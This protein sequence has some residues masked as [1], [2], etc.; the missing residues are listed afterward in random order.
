VSAVLD[1]E[2]LLDAVEPVVDD[3][4]T[5]G[6]RNQLDSTRLTEP[7]RRWVANR[8]RYL[9]WRA[10][11]TIGKSH[12]QAWDIVHTARGT[13]PCRPVKRPPVLLLVV[14]YSWAQMDPLCKKLWDLLPKDEIHP[15]V[16]YE[17][18]NGFRGFKEP[19]IP[20]VSGPGAGSAISFATYE[21]GAGRIMG[22]QV[23]G[24]Y[25]DEP[26][27]SS[28]YGE[29]VPRLNSKKGFLRISFTPTPESPDLEYMRD[30][31]KKAAD[32][33]GKRGI[34]EQQTS[35]TEGALVRRHGFGAAAIS[36][37]I[38]ELPA[39]MTADEIAESLDRY[40]DE[41]RD[42]REHGAWYPLAK[43]RWVSTFT[44]E[45]VSDAPPPGGCWLVVS[46]DHGIQAGKQAAMASAYQGRLNL[47]TRMW[48]LGESQSDGATDT[49]E[50]AVA[51]L[52]MLESCGLSYFDVDQW[53]GDRSAEDR[54][55]VRKDNTKVRRALAKLLKLDLDDPRLKPIRTV[56]KHVGSPR[57]GAQLLKAAFKR[58]DENGA[59]MA[60][61]HSRC[62]RFR[63]SLLKFKGDP[64][65]PVKDIF[66]AGR[67]GAEIATSSAP[68][69]PVRGL[70]G[71]TGR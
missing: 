10:G 31:V 54:R 43:G 33:N 35:L 17:Q 29:V 42:M 21:Q 45:N 55:L 9:L 65:D 5:W 39:W 38:G 63:D 16:R 50:D 59:P 4:A 34:V 32:S 36:P 62:T 40:L 47:D 27:P 68:W 1:A 24:A 61:V 13:H 51:I 6:S 7:Q 52:A 37:A 23:D 12:G 69:S 22:V 53:V 57:H 14:G 56:S 19:V 18:N 8:G 28:V 60:F 49:L 67:Y 20:F 46:L 64:R 71:G 70:Y 30:E 41:E 11:N 66:D 44:D 15:K 2:A 48:F 3:D 25:L 26:P 58:R